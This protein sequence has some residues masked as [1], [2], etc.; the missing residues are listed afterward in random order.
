MN[1]CINIVYPIEGGTFPKSDPA[2]GSKA[3]YFTASFSTTCSG[4]DFKVRWGFDKDLL[5][6]GEYYD[7]MSA[8]FVWKLP[9]GKHTFWVESSKCEREEVEFFIG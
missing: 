3:S 1:A 2:C 7:Q 9:E 6:S 5:G 4:G 8:Q